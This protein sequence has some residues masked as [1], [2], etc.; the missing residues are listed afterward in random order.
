[1]PKFRSRSDGSHYPIGRRNP[2][3]SRRSGIENYRISEKWK[4]RRATGSIAQDS[5]G[6]TVNIGDTV[7]VTDSSAAFSITH[8]RYGENNNFVV[9]GI[10]F[11]PLQGIW[12]KIE[13]PL[14]IGSYFVR[15]SEVTKQ[16]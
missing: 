3:S 2:L 8:L 4:Q 11:T 10:S 14:R 5:N 12:L 13:H 15:D 1:M 16:K 7:A 9:K 6:N